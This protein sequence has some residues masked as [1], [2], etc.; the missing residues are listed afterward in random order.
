MDEL[1]RI[2]E[3]KYRNDLI[4]MLNELAMVSLG[5]EEITF[6]TAVGSI[7]IKIGGKRKHNGNKRDSLYCRYSLCYGN[8]VC[9]I[10]CFANYLV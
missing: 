3:E 7:T 10:I 9:R 8:N 2:I 4:Q 1:R 5:G 6:D